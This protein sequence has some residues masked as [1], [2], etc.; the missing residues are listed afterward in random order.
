VSDSTTEHLRRATS[1]DT[2]DDD[3]IVQHLDGVLDRI[4]AELLTTLL[5]ESKLIND[6]TSIF[7]Q[8]D[9][10]VPLSRENET[11]RSVILFIPSTD[12]GDDVWPRPVCHLGEILKALE[13]FRR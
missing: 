4:R 11:V 1:D 3:P 2:I 10:F 8:A 12:P 13:I 5:F 6:D 9:A 7:D